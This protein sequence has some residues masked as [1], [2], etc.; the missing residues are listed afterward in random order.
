MPAWPRQ[1]SRHMDRF[2]WRR[3]LRRARVVCAE[4][5]LSGG[6]GCSLRV[7]GESSVLCW[8]C[9]SVRRRRGPASRGLGEPGAE[10]AEQRRDEA[11]QGHRE[12]ARVRRSAV[13]RRG[14]EGRPRLERSHDNL[15]SAQPLAADP[16]QR[17]VAQQPSRIPPQCRAAG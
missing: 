8:W 10:R 1:M 16:R 12:Q 13:G 5:D 4:W 3:L 11:E 14:Q 6:R 9:V 7:T 17:S 15:G 2:E